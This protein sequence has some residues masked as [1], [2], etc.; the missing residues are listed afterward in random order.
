MKLAQT[1]VRGSS[2]CLDQRS[3]G[4]AA[5][6]TGEPNFFILGA[7]SYG[8]SSHFLLSVGLEQIRDVFKR[9]TGRESLDLYASMSRGAMRTSA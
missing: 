8:R 2:D 5:L 7:K 1:L 4:A 6:A 9:I 3:P